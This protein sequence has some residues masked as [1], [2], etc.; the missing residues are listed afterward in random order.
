MADNQA[1]IAEQPVVPTTAS[2]QANRAVS[3]GSF[4]SGRFRWVICGVLFIGISKNYMDRQVLGV[5]KVTLQ[6]ELGWNEIDYGNLV[7]AFQMAY[8]VGL[9]AV[10]RFIDRVGSRIGYGLSMIFWSLA[11]MAHAFCG[12]LMT[13]G[14]AR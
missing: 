6:R 10:G 3:P 9:L 4:L 12:S 2:I 5:L 14:I 1:R 7:F 11:S 8:A 13:F